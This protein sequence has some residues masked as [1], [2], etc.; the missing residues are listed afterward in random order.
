MQAGRG[1]RGVCVMNEEERQRL[2]V[3]ESNNRALDEECEMLRRLVKKLQ[4]EQN[5]T[6]AVLR[7]IRRWIEAEDKPGEWTAEVYDA[8]GKALD[9]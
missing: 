5:A 4:A 6:Q 7:Q 8:A 9:Y 2:A 1:K 3:A